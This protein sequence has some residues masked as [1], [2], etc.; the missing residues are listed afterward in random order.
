MLGKDFISNEEVNEETDNTNN[1]N[2]KETKKDKK[3][4]QKRESK[5]VFDDYVLEKIAFLTTK[6]VDGILELKG[7]IWSGLTGALNPGE[8]STAGVTIEKEDTEVFVEIRAILEYGKSA[9]DIFEQLKEAIK[10][11]INRITG[12]EVASVNMK[13]VDVMNKDEYNQ[14]RAKNEQLRIDKIEHDKIEEDKESLSIESDE[15]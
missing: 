7:G 11:E 10:I 13:V 15:K 5:L 3:R 14:K 1:T 6:K 2:K 8:I 12:L 9:P 4:E